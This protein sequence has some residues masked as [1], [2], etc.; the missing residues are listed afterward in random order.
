MQM[1]TLYSKLY[2]K[3]TKLKT[4]KETEMDELNREQ[5]LKFMNFVTA[6]EEL[7][8]HLR[9]EDDRLKTQ[10][11]ELTEE[12]TTVRSAREAQYAEYQKLL[13]EETEK[14]KELSLEVE[15]LQSMQRLGFCCSNKDRNND[16]RQT[17]SP[18][19]TRLRS[20]NLLKGSSR[21]KQR[22][23][24]STSQTDQARVI[25]PDSDQEMLS[26]V[27]ESEKTDLLNTQQENYCMR[28]TSNSAAR[29][30]FRNFAECL[31]GMKIFPVNENTGFCFSALHQSS[32]YSFSLRWYCKEGEE[33]QA[34]ILYN[35]LSLGTFE[36]VAP[37]WMKEDIM[38]STNMCPVF[39]KRLSQVIDLV[40]P[41]ALALPLLP[42]SL[43]VCEYSI[44]P[45]FFYGIEEFD[46][47]LLRPVSVLVNCSSTGYFRSTMGVRQGDP[48]SPILFI[49]VAEALS[50]VF[51]ELFFACFKAVS[52]LSINQEK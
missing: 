17:D 22:L 48:L 25:S 3:Y 28:K 35:I 19:S 31:V 20:R 34:E 12:V 15:R 27:R 11:E 23:M 14:T 37:E 42:L 2:D 18:R 44:S 4:R 8:E 46:A 13:K 39:F 49:V 29:C 43:S 33:Q 30:M 10:I 21:K 36:R 32:G 9:N 1:E 16:N 45:L 5:E 7:I 6:S 52:G 24:D 40:H 51:L 26:V 50:R 38:F 41:D 47:F